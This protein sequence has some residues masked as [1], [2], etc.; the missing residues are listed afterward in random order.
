MCGISSEDPYELKA[1][2]SDRIKEAAQTDP[3]CIELTR[4]IH[5]G[6]PNDQSSMDAK[7]Q[8]Y[9]KLR[10]ELYNIDGV[11]IFNGRVV[12]PASLRKEVLECLHSA[13]Q[14]VVGMKARALTSVYWPGLSNAIANR[15]QQCK[16]CNTIAPS[17]PREPLT[18]SPAPAFPFEKTVADYFSL[19]GRTF[20]VYADRYTGWVT[21][22]RCNTNELNADHLKRE[23]RTLFGMFGAPEELAT[24]GGQ[25]F[26]SYCIQQFLD[27]W[28]V[29][30]R[31]SSA[32]YPQSNGR[33]ELA[34]KTAKRILY[35]NTKPNGDLNTDKV[36]R[37]L[38]QYRNTPIQD[39]NI[40][41]AQ[42]LYGRT[43]RD[44]LPSMSEAL[45]IRPE[46]S[47]LA[48]DRERALAKRHIMNMERYDEHTKTLPPL[49]K[50]DT[51][52]LQNQSGPHPKRW[53]KTGLI[54]EVRD[55]QQYVIRLHG[56]GRCTL[57][58]RRFLRRCDPFCS[59]KPSIRWSPKCSPSH[60]V[61]EGGGALQQTPSAPS[62]DTSPIPND[63][64]ECTLPEQSP[65]KS[66]PSSTS[67]TEPCSTSSCGDDTKKTAVFTSPPRRSKRIR[68]PRME[69]SLRF[70]GKHYDYCP[71]SHS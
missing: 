43:L 6:F 52:F 61:S 27:D 4:L 10:H 42:L 66:T 48:E 47:R 12:V 28:G 68:K 32:Y 9:W 2:T 67:S 14:G 54:T 3:E 60:D 36:A 45:R 40:S 53:D 37:A 41:P 56:T 62:V 31:Q 64:P 16:T 34:V 24:D 44:H 50:G 69:L 1:I 5:D 8:P 70:D 59:D 71:P 13:H 29:K 55:H 17:Q 38:L 57:R 11:T 46:W 35:D 21:V 18:P 20:L 22:A 39:L 23:L 15:R 19:K 26:A 33:A 7:L 63:P 58:N 49:H 25:P 65:D 51:V 30:W